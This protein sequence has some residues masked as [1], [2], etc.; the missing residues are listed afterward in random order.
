VTNGVH[1]STWIAPQF[2]IIYTGWLGE[3]WIDRQDDSKIWQQVLSIPDNSIW[4][5]HRWLK[6]KLISSILDQARYRWGKDKV[7]PIQPLA[8]G[9]LLDTEALTIGFCRRFTAYKRADLIFHDI[10]RLKRI[11]NGELQPVQIIFAGKA[12]PNDEDGKRKIQR[13]YN[14]AK[15]PEFG[16]RIAFVEDYDMNIAR[17]LVSGVDVWLNTPRAPMEASGT[18]GQKASLNGV[19]NLSVLDGWWREAYNGKNG[20]AI[21][22][23]PDTG[24][25]EER[26]AH[27]ANSLYEILEQRVVPLFYNRD[28]DGIPSEWVK[29][30][31]ES[32]ISN[33]C[34][35]N[36]CRMAKEYNERF[37]VKAAKNTLRSA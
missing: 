5:I 34:F 19:L 17:D 37:Y 13:V 30:M 20:W 24:S 26:D 27:T 4:A 23:D 35:F 10:E 14:I 33:S 11:L 2:H 1:L 21:E 16:G 25:D 6:L 22:E 7:A 18:S 9:A 32:I 8:M 3:N 29:M 31:K 28:M 15:D 36:T 12:H